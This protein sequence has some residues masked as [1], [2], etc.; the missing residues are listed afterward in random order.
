MEFDDVKYDRQLIQLLQLLKRHPLCAGKTI[1]GLTLRAL[2]L[3]GQ[4]P[5]QCCFAAAVG[6]HKGPALPLLKVQFGNVQLMAFTDGKTGV[7][8]TNGA[9]ESGSFTVVTKIT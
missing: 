1:L 2:Q 6:T 8:D 4:R 5:G 7:L 3:T 9:H